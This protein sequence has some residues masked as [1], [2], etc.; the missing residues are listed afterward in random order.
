MGKLRLD[1][2]WPCFLSGPA[3]SAKAIPACCLRSAGFQACRLLCGAGCGGNGIIFSVVAAEMMG[4]LVRSLSDP[5]ADLCR[6]TY[7]SRR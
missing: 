5:D 7:K 2:R 1:M 6:K 4:R 3:H